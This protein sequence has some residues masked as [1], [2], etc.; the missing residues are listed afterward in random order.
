MTRRW[1]A[2]SCVLATLAAAASTF[3]ARAQERP[4]IVPTAHPLVPG[5]VSQYWLVPDRSA[6]PAAGGNRQETPT[7]RVARGAQ[8][9]TDGNFAGGLP[10]VTGSDVASSPLAGYAGYYAGL[11]LQRLARLADADAALTAVVARKP[12]GYLGE[13]V[14]LRLADV[15]IARQDAARAEDL[16]EALSRRKLSAPEEVFLALGRAEE[17]V[18]HVEHALDAYRR[19]YYDFP[20]SD[21]A[22]DAQAAIERLQTPSLIPA[23]RF[24]RELAR[25]ETLFKASRW[26]Q[27]KAGFTPLLRAVQ[28]DQ[29]DLIALRLAECDY[30]LDR[31]RASRDALRPYLDDG[32]RQPEARYFHLA[33]TRGLGDRVAF[34]ALTRGLV[35]DHPGSEWAAEALNSLASYYIRIDEDA[36]ADSVLRDLLQRF[37]KH[38]YA[39]RA[40]WKVG[41]R[42]Y[43]A[44]QFADAADVFDAA[45]AAF[46]RSDYRPSW[47]YWSGRSHDRAGHA[48][49]AGMRYQVVRA[50]YQN[51]YYGRLVSPLLATRPAPAVEQSGSRPAAAGSVPNDA[52]IRGLVA[53]NM[54]GEALAEVQYAQRVWGDSSQLQA[55]WA[56]IRHQQ[57]RGLKAQERFNAIRGAITAMRRAY[58]QFLAA[59]GERL[60]PEVLRIIF[61]LDFWPLITKYAAAH[62]LD[63]YLIAALMAQESTFTPEIRS[64]A[65]AYGL[66]QLVPPTGRQVARSLGLTYSRSMLTQAEPNIRLG[67]KYFKDLV[68]AY[69]GVAYAL[70][71]YNAGPDRVKRWREELPG[72][73]QDEFID[74]ITF[75]ETQ[76]YVRRIL[77]TAEDYRRLYSPGGPLDPQEQLSAPAPP[78]TSTRKPPT[79]ATGPRR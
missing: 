24:A 31:F 73:P 36:Q 46:P 79:A 65:N 11:A 6:A 30:H 69:G 15:A 35:N 53:A 60:P 44:G 48:A 13:L 33:S 23:D 14:M 2:A 12:E 61:P 25:A 4:G 18:G 41:W 56:W 64:Y 9:I 26:A 78:A 40:A 45:S 7:A 70:A 49:A 28:G 39:E 63:P 3:G 58:P 32:P 43:R 54:L 5:H 72:L 68:R 21:Q 8:L 71:G 77:G 29:R 17:A 1:R 16:L 52:M 20:L 67:T 55:T 47:L 22:N 59:G 66:M 27:A 75:P 74:S 37:P 10:L 50:D 51:S 76:A 34:V 38:R 42:A 57:G 19:L 62:D